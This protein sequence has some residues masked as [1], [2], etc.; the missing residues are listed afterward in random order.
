MAENESRDQLKQ[1]IL[2]HFVPQYA[3]P[4]AKHRIAG[5]LTGMSGEKHRGVREKSPRFKAL[6]SQRDEEARR[7]L[8]KYTNTFRA[9]LNELLTHL[10]ALYPA[11]S[12]QA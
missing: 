1:V 5:L 10:Q 12:L 11:T 4:D 6:L 2:A 9:L 8:H 7:C 3:L